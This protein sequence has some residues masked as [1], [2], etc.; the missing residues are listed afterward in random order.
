MYKLII[1]EN[2]AE[3][4]GKQSLKCMPPKHLRSAENCTISELDYIQTPRTHYNH[5]AKV[6]E[7]KRKL[8]QIKY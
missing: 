5:L 4:T 2:P 8:G 1:F 7:A 3:S 6:L